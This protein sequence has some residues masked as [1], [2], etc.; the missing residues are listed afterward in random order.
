MSAARWL[1]VAEKDSPVTCQ[2]TNQT[3]HRQ[4][5]FFSNYVTNFKLKKTSEVFLSENI[6]KSF[7]FTLFF[8]LTDDEGWS[9][10]IKGD[11]PTQPNVSL[12]FKDQHGQFAPDNILTHNSELLQR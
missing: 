7:L 5:P 9:T 6:M 11:A 8:N 1:R 2:M 12:F 3:P 10:T 4:L